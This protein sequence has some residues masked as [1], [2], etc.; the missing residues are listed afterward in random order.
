MA[1]GNLW[2]A[3]NS[4]DSRLL[5]EEYSGGC[6]TWVRPGQTDTTGKSK[7]SPVQANGSVSVSALRMS[8]IASSV[9][10]LLC[11]GSMLL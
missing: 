2:R 10:D 3:A 7:C 5:P 11:A 4:T 1:I 8:S 6:G 9:R